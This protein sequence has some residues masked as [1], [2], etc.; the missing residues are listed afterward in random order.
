MYSNEKG[1]W[2]T[3]FSPHKNVQGNDTSSVRINLLLTI[4]QG[5]HIT[6]FTTFIKKITIGIIRSS[7]KS[8]KCG[9][10]M[11]SLVKLSLQK[12]NIFHS[13]KSTQSIIVDRQHPCLLVIGPCFRNLV[14]QVDCKR[15]M[16]HF[17]QNLDSCLAAAGAT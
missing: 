3:L 16:Q 12:K 6:Y 14:P 2:W 11:V 17:V 8:V 10:G 1:R 9:K 15:R 4:Y 13:S 5:V 7:G